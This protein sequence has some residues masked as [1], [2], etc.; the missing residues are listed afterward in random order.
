MQTTQ[1][2]LLITPEGLHDFY[3][4]STVKYF[5]TV[6]RALEVVEEVKEVFVDDQKNIDPKQ[7]S[8]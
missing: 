8:I 2:K 1:N 4:H 3:N 7:H 6:S 5:P